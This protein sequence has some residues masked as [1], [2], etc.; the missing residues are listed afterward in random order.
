MHDPG[1]RFPVRDCPSP[2]ATAPRGRSS[3]RT[4]SARHQNPP[5]AEATFEWPPTADSLAKKKPS[6]GLT[7]S[8]FMWMLTSSPQLRRLA[9]WIVFCLA[10]AAPH[11]SAR[12]D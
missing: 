9:P 4:V 3:L 1:A 8:K 12:E 7:M 11:A 2:D 5:I 10:V 6:G